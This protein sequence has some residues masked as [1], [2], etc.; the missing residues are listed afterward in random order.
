VPNDI[1]SVVGMVGSRMDIVLSIHGYGPVPL[2]I[3]VR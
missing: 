3:V 1:A 2:S